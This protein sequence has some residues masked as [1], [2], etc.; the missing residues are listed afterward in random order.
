MKW[1][2]GRQLDSYKMTISSKDI[3]DILNGKN[4]KLMKNLLQMGRDYEYNNNEFKKIC[5]RDFNS[6]IMNE[7]KK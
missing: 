2:K 4:K 6:S 1:N 7:R 3:A 5:G